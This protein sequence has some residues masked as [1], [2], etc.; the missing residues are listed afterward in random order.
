MPRWEQ[1]RPDTTISQRAG[2]RRAARVTMSMKAW[3]IDVYGLR[4]AHHRS[5]LGRLRDTHRLHVSPLTWFPGQ[6]SRTGSGKTLRRGNRSA[7][8]NLTIISQDPDLTPGG[9]AGGLDAT[10]HALHQR[11]MLVVEEHR[12]CDP[13]LVA[14]VESSWGD[15]GLIGRPTNETLTAIITADQLGM[16]L[17][18]D[19]AEVHR[20]AGHLQVKTIT[21]LDLASSLAA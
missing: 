21:V 8:G 15:A 11:G 7:P 3:A 4:G 20:L 10:L 5:V 16:S 14:V 9:R 2:T 19:D 18:T 12:E 13:H 6:P 17:V 1:S